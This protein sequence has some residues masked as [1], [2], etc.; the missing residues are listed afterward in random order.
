MFQCKIPVVVTPTE[1][2]NDLLM[3]AAVG[4]NGIT[5]SEDYVPENLVSLND[6]VPN[7]FYKWDDQQIS[8][9]AV[10]YI[11]AWIEAV[12]QELGAVPYFTYGYRSYE[13]QDELHQGNPNGA[14]EAGDSQHQTGLTFDVTQYVTEENGELIWHTACTTRGRAECEITVRA[15]EIAQEL[16]IAHPIAWD[17]PHFF[18]AAAVS[19]E[20]TDY[21]QS[22]EDPVMTTYYDELNEE[23][24]RLQNETEQA[25]ES[26]LQ[27]N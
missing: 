9:E 26:S 4:S 20:L 7:A 27:G 24:I 16:G 8:E 11:Q 6:V 2:D 13:L 23:I 17:G 21:I 5:L 14:A 10:E 1:L 15:I 25:S 19:D 18:V 12:F 22:I 3:N